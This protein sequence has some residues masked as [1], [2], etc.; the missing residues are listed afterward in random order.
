M[1][2]I[3]PCV[4][5]LARWLGSSNTRHAAAPLHRCTDGPSNTFCCFVV[6]FV[7]PRVFL[8]LFRHPFSFLELPFSQ[9][10]TSATVCNMRCWKKKSVTRIYAYFSRGGN[11]RRHLCEPL[12][13][14]SIDISSWFVSNCVRVRLC[15]VNVS[16]EAYFYLLHSPAAWWLILI[17]LTV[18]KMRRIAGEGGGE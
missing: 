16:I 7:V 13:I 10:R 11:G 1:F 5:S 3:R 2:C 12:A 4:R 17:G 14:S 6:C 8:L 15:V 18:R 9:F